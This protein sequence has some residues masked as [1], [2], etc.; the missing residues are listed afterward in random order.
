MDVNEAKEK[1]NEMK[2]ESQAQAIVRLEQEIQTRATREVGLIDQIEQL[3]DEIKRL[4]KEKVD[5]ENREHRSNIAY[6]K[7]INI[8]EKVMD[9]LE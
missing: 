9:K 2:I 4:R 1:S 7:L 3:D 8:F 6:N 5:S